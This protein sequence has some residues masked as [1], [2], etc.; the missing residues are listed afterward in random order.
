MKKKLKIKIP[1]EF[2]LTLFKLKS[3]AKPLRHLQMKILKDFK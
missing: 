2:E 1:V 3:T